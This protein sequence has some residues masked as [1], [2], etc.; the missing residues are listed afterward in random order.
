MGTVTK[1]TTI[2]SGTAKTATNISS[3]QTEIE[4]LL[5]IKESIIIGTLIIVF[6]IILLLIS[7]NA[8]LRVS[9][10]L[11]EDIKEQNDMSQNILIDILEEVGKNNNSANEQF[12]Q[13][14]NFN[15]QT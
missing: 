15:Q 5:K 1:I 8:Y 6:I 4:N 11:L 2:Y 9:K 12:N 3:I 14:R 13:Q 7:I 10:E